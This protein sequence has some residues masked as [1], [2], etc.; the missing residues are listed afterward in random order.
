M[1]IL[2]SIKVPLGLKNVPAFFQSIVEEV[3]RPVSDCSSN[4]IDDVLVYSGNWKEQVRHLEEVIKYF[5]GAGLKAKSGKCEF[6]RKLCPI[7]GI[8]LVV[9]N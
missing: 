4:C 2:F 1:E 7:W 8:R 3:L 6:G 9:V 5:K